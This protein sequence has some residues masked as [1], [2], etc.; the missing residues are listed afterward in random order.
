MTTASIEKVA[1]LGAGSMGHGIAEVAAIAGYDVTIRDLV[2][3][4]VG[5]VP[6]AR[7]V[8]DSPETGLIHNL[9]GNGSVHS[10]MTLARDPQ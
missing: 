6:D 8:P 5:D 7:A 3:D 1:V 2:E 4:G 9:S 10:V